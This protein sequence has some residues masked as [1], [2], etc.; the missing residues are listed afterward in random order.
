VPSCAIAVT[1]NISN[2]M[3]AIPAAMNTL[4]LN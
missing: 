1:P 2:A 3:P 4:L